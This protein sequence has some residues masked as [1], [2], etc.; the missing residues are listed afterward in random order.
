M[1]AVS[2]LDGGHGKGALP[3]M[4][5]ETS[6]WGAAERRL[7]GWMAPVGPHGSRRRCTPPHHEGL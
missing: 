5:C 4:F 6:S 7:E 1:D 3:T 2:R